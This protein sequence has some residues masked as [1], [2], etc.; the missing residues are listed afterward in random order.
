MRGVEWRSC[1][2]QLP[3]LLPLRILYDQYNMKQA[4][5]Q[6]I[7]VG[8]ACFHVGACWSALQAWPAA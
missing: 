6:V 2:G 7:I 1:A 5:V 3:V 4:T 8:L